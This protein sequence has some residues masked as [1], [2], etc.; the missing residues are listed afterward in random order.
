MS[1]RKDPPT[2]VIRNGIVYN[3]ADRDVWEF[4]W[5]IREPYTCPSWG[6]TTSVISHKIYRCKESGDFYRVYVNGS[7]Q[8]PIGKRWIRG[9][10]DN[11]KL[12]DE[13]YIKA[14]IELKPYKYKK[15]WWKF[16]RVL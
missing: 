16:W 1:L 4:I 6:L 13:A 3:F 8:G 7:L 15:Q 5:N 10:F 14:G 11:H 9:Q 12:P 2:E